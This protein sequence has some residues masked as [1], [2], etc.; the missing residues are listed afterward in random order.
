MSGDDIDRTPAL[1]ADVKALRGDFVRLGEAVRQEVAVGLH[2]NSEQTLAFYRVLEE[3][4]SRKDT[5]DAAFQA[6]MR[7]FMLAD[8]AW[9]EAFARRLKTEHD[10]RI[11]LER[12]ATRAAEELPVSVFGL[13]PATWRTALVAAVV[14]AL[15]SP[16]VACGAYGVARATSAPIHERDASK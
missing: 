14:F 16:L 2:R 10:Q 5:E 11:A 13:R 12:E 9:K 4:A 1:F 15:M 6:E 3:R 8:Q 7:G